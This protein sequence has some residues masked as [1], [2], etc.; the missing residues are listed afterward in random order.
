ME[1]VRNAIDLP[2]TSGSAPGVPAGLQQP[3]ADLTMTIESPKDAKNAERTADR[4][5]G[6]P[7]TVEQMQEIDDVDMFEQVPPGVQTVTSGPKM[8]SKRVRKLPRN[9]TE[10][11]LLAVGVSTLLP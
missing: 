3:Q 8:S 7:P 6:T 1:Q 2:V 9:V 5:V 11:Y 4:P 10:G